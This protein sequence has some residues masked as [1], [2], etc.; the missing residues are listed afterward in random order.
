[1]IR[2]ALAALLLSPASAVEIQWFQG[3]YS[4]ALEKARA[5]RKPVFVYFWMDGSE[6]CAQVYG[7]TL[8]T[9]AAAAE[10]ADHICL[11]ANAAEPE[12][13]ELIKRYNVTTLP[14]M[15]FITPDGELEDAILGFIPI[16]AFVSEMQRIRS[17]T[18]TVSARRVA[19]E[20]SPDDL[21][22]RLTLALKLDWVGDKQA[23]EALL[24]SIRREDPRGKT[25]A[26][27]QLA[28]RDVQ[29]KIVDAASD[30][31]DQKTFDLRPIYRHL[32]RVKQG[33]V[34]FTGWDWVARIEAARGDRPKARKAY[35]EAWKHIPQTAVFGWGREVVQEYWNNR[36]ELTRGDKKFALEVSLAA[37][38]QADDI[39]DNAG[40][41]EN[42]DDEGRNIVAVSISLLASSYFMNGD[43]DKALAAIERSIELD[44]QNEGFRR[45]REAF[46]K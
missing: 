44:S 4:A 15:L 23:S 42:L 11:S 21:D 25:L 46:G 29:Q 8:T 13:A 33:S 39:L 3:S 40:A 41:E 32:P 10:L 14:T 30:A 38:A 31:N 2:L 45:L 26:G 24:D 1:M 35:M 34:A 37:T 22:L 28:L 17:G 7:Q 9:D 5:E 20:A 18:E 43:R 19:A 27:A 6:Y 36:D 16:T 12:G